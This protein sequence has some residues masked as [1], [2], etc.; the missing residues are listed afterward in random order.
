MSDREP[1]NSGNHIEVNFA[2]P[3]DAAVIA[4]FNQAMALETENKDLDHST[5][6]SGV[7]SVFENKDLGFYLVARVAG[8]VVGCLLVTTEWSD[9]R[10]GMFWWIQS[11]YVAPGSRGKGVFS[12][13]YSHVS[14]E[15]RSR[16]DVCGLRLYV[17]KENERARRTYLR[18]G[19]TETDY[20]LLEEE[21]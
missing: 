8:A 2:R 20:R 21:F 19:M 14:H 7:T 15:A 11:V 16:S 4:D 12:A 5:L 3:E 1:D 17:E 10:N 9:W 18:L 6:L 13:L